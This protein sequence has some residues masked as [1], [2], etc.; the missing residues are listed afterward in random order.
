MRR[1]RLSRTFLDQL[2]T[3]LEQ[4]YPRFGQPVVLDK[5]ERV[6]K[7]IENHL[8]HYPRIPRDPKHGLC[9]YPVRK[10]PFVVVYD[11]DDKE[12]RV[13]FV[14]HEHDDYANLD[15]KSVEW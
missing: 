5:R 15:P 13:C 3:L 2:H 12:L 11:Y 10:T 9:V 7:L 4:G 6:F 14:F 1:V 8:A